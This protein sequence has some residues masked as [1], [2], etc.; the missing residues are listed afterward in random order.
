MATKFHPILA[1]V[2]GIKDT[3]DLPESF[4]SGS[5]TLAY[6][7][8]IYDK[9][10]NIVAETPSGLSPNVQLS[11]VPATDTQTLM[12]IYESV[13]G[14]PGTGGVIRGQTFPPGGLLNDC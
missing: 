8:Q 10:Q 2:D 9:G 14:T 12:L 11:F 1:Q 6:N 7:G 4:V 3:F 5:V 13:T